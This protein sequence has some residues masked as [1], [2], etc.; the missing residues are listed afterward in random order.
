[1]RAT[2]Y[3]DRSRAGLNDRWRG[4]PVALAAVAAVGIG[5]LTAVHPGAAA[6]VA[7]VLVMVGVLLYAPSAGGPADLADKRFRWVALA[8]TYVMIRPIGHFTT[9]RTSLSAVGGSASPENVLDLAIHAAIAAAAIWSLRT[10][11]F[12]LRSSGLLLALP[13]VA[14]VSAAWSLT[15]TTTLGF[16]FELIAAYLLATVTAGIL[17]ADPVL[18]RSVVSCTLRAMVLLVTALCVIGLIFPHRGGLAA[19]VLPGDMRFTW[20]GV[21]PLVATAEIG[22]AFLITVFATRAELG[23][24]RWLRVALLILFG[25]CLYLGQSRTPFAGLIAGGLFA[26]WLFTRGRG[27]SRLAGIGAVAM[28]VLLVVSQFGGPVAQ[29]LYRG[30]SQQQVFGLNG[31]LGL[32]TFVL[33]QLHTPA[34]VIF[35]YGLSADRV[36]LASSITWAGDAHGAWLELLI[37]LGLV[38]VTVGAI[39]VVAV[40][41]RLVRRDPEQPPAS[42]VLPVLFV[43]SLAMSAA[44]TGFAVPGPEPGLGFGLLAFCYA[45]TATRSHARLRAPAPA[46][47]PQFELRRTMYSEA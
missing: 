5:A 41:F 43:Y 8:W 28:I 24:R 33:S 25:V 2:S 21:H 45:A 17:A 22:L 34:Q 15:S 1:M 18:G 13:A 9:G 39:V 38:G 32:W 36:L 31:R 14:L 10:N 37:S 47:V 11:R 30:E 42:R 6:V 23:F 40:L 3:R 35:G 27:W 12:S 26:L 4:A 20:P 16:S 46:T 19:G 44:A 29:Y 7:A